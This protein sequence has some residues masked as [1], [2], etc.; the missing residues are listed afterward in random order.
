MI[1]NYF[2]RLIITNKGLILEQVLAI[3]GLRFQVVLSFSQFLQR[4][5]IEEKPGG[6]LRLTI[7]MRIYR[8][9]S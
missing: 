1:L 2:K 3:K 4:S 6:Y 8:V 9:D 7:L 5:S